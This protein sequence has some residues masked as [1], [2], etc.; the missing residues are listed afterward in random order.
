[1]NIKQSSITGIAM[2]IIIVTVFVG[3]FGSWYIGRKINYKLL[4]K[5]FV[6]QT[7][8]NMVEKECLQKR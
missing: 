1:M 3:L 7:V 8:R 2:A 4:Y 6:E 5:A